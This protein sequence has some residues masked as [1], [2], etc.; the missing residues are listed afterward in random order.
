[1]GL[2]NLLAEEELIHELVEAV[3][4]TSG[5]ANLDDHRLRYRSFLHN[6]LSQ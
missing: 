4:E 3:K 2:R 1:M 5:G 6:R